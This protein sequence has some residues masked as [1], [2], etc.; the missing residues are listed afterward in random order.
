MTDVYFKGYRTE[1]RPFI[2]QNAKKILEIGCGEGGFRT[3][4]GDDVEYWGVEPNSG[5]AFVSK[6]KFYKVLNGVYDDVENELPDH[7]FDLIVCN[8]VIEHM[9]DH[10]AFFEKIKNKMKPDGKMLMSIPNV[11]YI[12]N[13]I[14]LLIK[15]DWEYKDFGI[16]D[17]THLRFFTKKS[18][19]NTLNAH[20]YEIIQFQ[21]VNKVKDTIV[22][23]I[24]QIFLRLFGQSD[25]LYPQ[26]ACVVKVK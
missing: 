14:K 3:N 13:L 24:P 22:T 20:N 9:I 1:L 6:E 12:T 25:T 2:P 8:D 23:V 17:R 21:G 11:R 19:K 7:Y 4:F 18:L 5:V 16:L 10:D 15:Q 26:F